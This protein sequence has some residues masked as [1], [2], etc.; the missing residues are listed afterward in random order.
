[1]TPTSFSVQLLPLDRPTAA[2]NVYSRET[3]ER[4]L[5][6]DTTFQERIAQGQMLGEVTSPPEVTNTNQTPHI[7]YKRVLTIDQSRVCLRVNSVYIDE[8]RNVLMGMVTPTG[9]MASVVTDRLRDQGDIGVSMR[10]FRQEPDTL[11][12]IVAFD[13]AELSDIVK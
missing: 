3:I 6:P 1:M 5:Q 12:V 9:P 13:L 11:K 2:G 4:F 7:R 8:E 10:S